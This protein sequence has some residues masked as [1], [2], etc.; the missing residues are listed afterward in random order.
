[1]SHKIINKF[2]LGGGHEDEFI[3]IEETK[4]LQLPKGKCKRFEYLLGKRR[5]SKKHG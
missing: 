1:M 3:E 2:D 5:Y 4:L